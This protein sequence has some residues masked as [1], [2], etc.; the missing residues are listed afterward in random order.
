[1]A[2]AAI[3]PVTATLFALAHYPDQ[4]LPGMEQAAVT[5]LVFGGIYAVTGQIWLLMIMHAAFDVTAVGL[6]Y[7]GWETNVAHWFL[8]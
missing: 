3:V 1:M 5:G 2:Q 4:G 8:Q 7:R 6:I